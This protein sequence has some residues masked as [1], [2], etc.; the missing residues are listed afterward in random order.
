MDCTFAIQGDDFILLANDK[1]VMR[2]IMKLQDSDVKTIKLTAHQLL[3]CVGEHYDRK[4][5]SKL[6][7]C[8][9]EL[10]NYQNGNRLNTEEVASYVRSQLAE[11]IRR[12]P[13][14]AN[15]LIAGYDNDGPKLYWLDYLGSIVRVA[16]AAHGYGAYFL[17]G[18]MDNYYKKGFNYN[19]GVDVIKK[20]IKELKTR[21]LVN[22]CEFDVFKITKDGIED[23]SEQ[24]KEKN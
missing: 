13:Y 18:L 16:K 24:F 21:F 6:I 10:Y 19:D 7:K 4:N 14:Q 8:N 20:C 23:V 12:N 17:Y 5:F 1:S 11:S 2:S 15:V 22:M 3:S 9:L